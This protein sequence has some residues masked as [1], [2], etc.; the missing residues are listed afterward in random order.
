MGDAKEV[1]LRLHATGGLRVVSLDD[2]N[3]EGENVYVRQRRAQR[4]LSDAERELDSVRKDMDEAQ[5]GVQDLGT[6]SAV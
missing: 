5:K 6:G 2:G 4:R 3:G 1:Q